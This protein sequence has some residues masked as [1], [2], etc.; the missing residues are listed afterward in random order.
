MKRIVVYICLLFLVSACAY[1]PQQATL[2]V[3]PEIAKAN[4]GA[5]KTVA[6]SVV[7]ERLEKSLGHR[8]TA[9]GK[10]AA[11]TTDQ[12]LT[13]VIREAFYKALTSKGFKPVSTLQKADKK[14]ETELRHFEY[15]TST[16]FWTGGIHVKGAMKVYASGSP[17]YENMYRIEKEERVVLVPGAESNERILNEGLTMLVEKIFQD[18]ALLNVLSR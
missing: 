6:V 17:K 13:K 14:L 4:I 9:Y 12:D 15:S 16:G 11:I 18:E 1:T 2:E 8:G 10:A 7:D 5:G 3:T